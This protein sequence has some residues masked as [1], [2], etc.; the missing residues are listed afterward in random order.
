MFNGGN[1][2]RMNSSQRTHIHSHAQQHSSHPPILEETPHEPA[3]EVKCPFSYSEMRQLEKDARYHHHQQQQ[4][5]PQ[6][7]INSSAVNSG[8]NDHLPRYSHSFRHPFHSECGLPVSQSPYKQETALRF[9]QYTSPVILPQ[10]NL[11][12]GSSTIRG[13]P[14]LSRSYFLPDV[15]ISLSNVVC[16]L[17]PS[18]QSQTATNLTRNVK[19]FSAFPSLLSSKAPVEYSLSFPFNLSPGSLSS[20]YNYHQSLL[21]PHPFFPKHKLDVGY[22]RYEGSLWYGSKFKP[23]HRTPVDTSQNEHSVLELSKD[24]TSA[25]IKFLEVNQGLVHVNQV[26]RFR[27]IEASSSGSSVFVGSKF[28]DATDIEYLS[29]RPNDLMGKPVELSSQESHFLCSKPPGFSSFLCDN[30]V[31]DVSRRD[32]Q[33]CS[34]EFSTDVLASSNSVVSSNIFSNEM[35]I[36]DKQLLSNSLL[37]CPE[38]MPT[39][40]SGVSYAESRPNNNNHN[41]LDNNNYN[42]ANSNHKGL[43]QTFF[44]TEVTRQ[45]LQIESRPW[46]IPRCQSLLSSQEKAKDSLPRW[47]TFRLFHECGNICLNV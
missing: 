28:E 9:S 37:N 38:Y 40:I 11:D 10:N 36:P 1:R 31:N 35:K 4:K 13:S 19:E 7:D 39:F 43:R 24:Q 21:Q 32:S 20:C 15:S 18:V 12:R 33:N 6:E 5:H 25:G 45:P 30:V 41:H 23:V 14:C 34:Q 8:S 42:V 22:P 17:L 2:R 29:K 16:S 3:E 44:G 27:V 47:G 26:E 46:G